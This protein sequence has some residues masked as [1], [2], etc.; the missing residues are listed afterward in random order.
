L[1]GDRYN[2]FVFT[3]ADLAEDVDLPL[4]A[5]K[6]ILYLHARLREID[7]WQLLGLRW[8]AS[9]DAA[10]AAYLDKVK[11]FHPDRYA[12]RRL[13]SFLARLE[14]VFRALTEARD[15][16]ADEPRRAEYAR[17]T[18]PPEEFARLEARRLEDEARA[19]E[20]RKRLARANPLVA[21]ASRVQDLVRRGKEALAQGNHARAAN[22]FLTALG[23]DPRHPEARALAAEAKRLSAAERARERYDHALAAEAVGN[24]AGALASAREAAEG[25]PATPRYAV[26]ASR[27][28]LETGDAGLARSL[29]E[30]AVRAAP[31]DARALEALGAALGAAGEARDA[32]RALER[33]LELDPSLQGARAHLKKLRW[34]FLG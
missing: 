15:A 11:V 5:K 34:S 30:G 29:A 18:A 14:R 17:R 25:D 33:A 31:R 19:D 6:E 10:R 28:A 13:G 22:D 21:R 12:G 20:R 27:L 24:R 23:I 16:L 1:P 26:T 2:G 3:P 4:E 9:S 8:N 7:H 32:R